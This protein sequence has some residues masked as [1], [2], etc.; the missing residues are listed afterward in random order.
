[1]SET[2]KITLDADEQEVKERAV[3]K[4]GT[5]SAKGILSRD[6]TPFCHVVD[7]SML[8]PIA[9]D[10]E[11]EIEQKQEMVFDRITMINQALNE[12]LRVP[13]EIAMPPESLWRTHKGK[14]IVLIRTFNAEGTKL[15][16]NFRWVATS[17]IHQ[18]FWTE[19]VAPQA[20]RLRRSRTQASGTPALREQS[21]DDIINQ[22]NALIDEIDRRESDE[23][24]SEQESESDVNLEL[25]VVDRHEFSETE[26]E[27]EVDLESDFDNIED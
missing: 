1:M 22:R 15:D 26:S 19:E 3:T 16:G 8:Q 21:L 9:T 11:D 27:S 10:S 20:K 13:D 25:D 7:G 17:D 4:M 24:E 12:T 6:L 23:P 18:C 2:K 5:A 14:K